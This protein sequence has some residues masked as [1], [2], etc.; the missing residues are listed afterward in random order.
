[1]IFFQNL[2]P[3]VMF[4]ILADSDAFGEFFHPKPED[5]DV[6]NIPN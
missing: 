6:I 1:M 4:D 5:L 3:F 2:I